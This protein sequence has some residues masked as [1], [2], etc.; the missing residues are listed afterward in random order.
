MGLITRLFH[1][2]AFDRDLDRELRFHIE[3]LT[4]ENL[5]RGMAPVEARRQAALAFGGGEQIKEELRDVHRLPVL[6]TT[7]RNLR[8]GLRT[9]RKA[10]AFSIAVILT[11]ALG[12]GANSAVF[13]AIDA[14]LLRPLPFPH[15]DRLML[16]QQFNQRNKSPNTFLAPVRLEDWNRMN[17]TFQAITG[18]YTEDASETS[19]PLPEKVTRA[20]V[21]PRFLQVWGVAPALG[22]DFTPDEEK[23]GGPSAVLISEH[24]WRRHFN[25]DS[26][27]VGQKL[28]FGKS[29]ETIVG[30]MPS[31]FRF[32]DRSVDLFSPVPVDSPYSQGRE[33]TW[34]TTI[35]RLKLGVTLA[36]ARADLA[37]VQ[38]RLARQF[39]TT[40]ADLAATVEP[41]KD[42]TVTES[43][44]SL[45]LLFGGVTVLLLIACTNIAG[46][47][48]ARATHREHEISVRFSLGASRGAIIAQLLAEMFV[49]ACA[50]S[51]LG[52]GISLGAARVFSA[53]AHNLPRV[54][55]IGL[56]WR[57][58]LY[59]LACAIAATFF[60]GTFPAWRATRARLGRSLARSSRAQVSARNPLQWVLAGV[61]VAL[62]VTL[63]VGAGLLLR[64]MQELARVSPGFDPSHVLTMHVSASYGETVDMKALTQR[65]N[66]ILETLR[67]VPGVDAAATSGTLPG[68]P[69]QYPTELKIVEAP[70]DPNRKIIVDTRFVSPAYFDTMRIPLLAGSP[71]RE[72]AGN[73]DVLVNRSFANTYFGQSPAAGHH[74]QQA[75]STSGF[76]L[77]GEIRGIVGDAREQGINSEPLPVVYFCI[78]APNPGVNYLVRTHT[79]PLQLA[80]TLRRAIRAIEPN[81]AVF[82]IMPLDT[83]LSDAFAETRMRTLLL[84]LF[85]ATSVALACVGLYGTLSYLVSVRRR[86]VGLRLALGAQRGQIARRFLFQGLRVSLIGCACGLALAAASARVLAGM[87]YGISPYDVT[88]I[89]LVLFM[90]LLVA[91]F[92]ALMPALRAARTDP[93]YVLR[94]E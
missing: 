85:A 49:L 70:A 13:S 3:E 20:Y 40:D 18:Y 33:S 48:L 65:I 57:I 30:V 16:L 38:A 22:R 59:C 4:R 54:D 27:V 73:P 69:R 52:L 68:I 15:G 55:E 80:E 92:A 41:L 75:A 77:T 44:N 83:R 9:I 61:Q 43:R 88:T 35:G 17:S 60:C 78:T 67:A 50:G 74:I 45:W 72:S 93:M 89:F 42:S 37:V 64:S 51:L 91:G 28:H 12:I 46:L 7:A 66:R 6:E 10:P 81:R 84:T 23:F 62:A 14:I 19:G 1:R 5:A 8:L 25:S 21:A 76:A 82:D 53:M 87:L 90:V 31:S 32:P 71:C 39:P 26:H 24:L 58:V 56:D 34:Y 2:R 79:E 47:L 94:E 36:Q 86:E 29:A 63:L 11:L